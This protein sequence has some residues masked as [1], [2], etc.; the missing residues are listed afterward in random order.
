MPMRLNDEE[1]RVR[2]LLIDKDTGPPPCAE[3]QRPC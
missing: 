2:L 3:G 1:G